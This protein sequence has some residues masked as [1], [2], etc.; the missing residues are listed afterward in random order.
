MPR[1][2]ALAVAL[3]AACTPAPRPGTVVISVPYQV[4]TLDPHA[5]NA[6]SNF[7]LVSQ[8]YEPLVVTDAE[9]RLHPGLAR[10]WENPDPS[11]WVFHLRPA[12]F[13]SGRMATAEDVVFSLRRLREQPGL[14]MSGY[15]HYIEEVAAVDQRTVRV[16]TT[17]PVAVLLNKL[18]FVA[19]VPAG[20]RGEDLAARPDG[21]GAYA[22]E[23]WEQGRRLRVRRRDHAPPGAPDVVEFLLDRSADEAAGDLLSGR[24]Q[25]AQVGSRAAL[26]RVR[27]TG[28]FRD[29][30]HPSLF[31]KFVAYDV[32]RIKTPYVDA[33]V[34]PFR[35][36][37]V[38]QAMDLALDRRRLVAALSTPA[39]PVDQLVPPAIFGFNP[40]LPGRVHDAAQARALLAEAG[41]PGGF[42]VRLHVREL[43]QEAAHVVRAQLGA[44]GIV[45]DV[46]VSDD[47]A[48]LDRLRRRDVSLYLSRF[49]CPTGD[50]S[51]ILDNTLHSPD[52]ARHL[53]GQ[54]YGGYSNSDVDAAIERSAAIDSV[55]ARR[56]ALERIME[57]LMTDL[58]WLP[59]YVDEDVYAFD[60]ALDF[61]PRSDSFILASELR[62]RAAGPR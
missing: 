31:V 7:A 60:P 41:Y 21:T 37:R 38:R 39:V 5:R 29:A 42:R 50:V 61:R 45:V 12:R 56:V 14:E 8:F 1:G 9:M 20:S 11:T 2:P 48:F 47:P 27:A 33:P 25:L 18:R 35:D 28:R 32:A 57:R 58:P 17:A 55:P 36:K 54:N 49:G 46:D 44:I 59:L 22:L 23:D 62:R 52:P 26:A 30:S 51:D 34:N 24:A 13:H 40:R 43:F 15:I 16:R 53:G 6:L 3:A 4:A 10:L 19:I